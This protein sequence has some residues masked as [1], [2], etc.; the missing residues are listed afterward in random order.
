VITLTDSKRQQQQEQ[1]PLPQRRQH[2][3]DWIAS[4]AELAA[5][6][7]RATAQRL[8]QAGT[9]AV[10]D[11]SEAVCLFLCNHGESHT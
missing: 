5:L 4:T 3:G 2:P 8:A 11:D 7:L 9:V 10:S 6:R 1:P